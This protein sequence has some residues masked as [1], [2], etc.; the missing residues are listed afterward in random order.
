MD[1]NSTHKTLYS[2][3]D[4]YFMVA[5]IYSEQNAQRSPT[6]TFAHFVE[7]C[8]ML[9]LHDNNKKREGFEV[10]DALCKALGWFF[11]LLAKFRVASVETLIFRKFPYAC[12]YC[13]KCPHVDKECKTTQGAKRTVDHMAVKLKLEEN[14]SKRPASLNQWRQM[15][16]DIYPRD[17]NSLGK[18][19]ST[20]GLLEELGELAEAVRVFDRHPKYFAGEVADVFSYLMGIANELRL[21]QQVAAKPEFDFNAEFLRRYPGLCVQC[22]HE[23]CVCPSVPESTVGRLAKEL[24]LTDSDQVFAAEFVTADQRGKRVGSSVLQEL[25][26]LA[27]IAHQLPLDRGD[28]NRAM[29]LLCL[30]IAEEIRPRSEQLALQ[31]HNAAF[32]IAADKRMAG[33]RDR[34]DTSA[35][36][37]SLLSSVWPLL[38]LAVIPEGTTLQARLAKLLRAQA[39]TIGI[40]TALPEEFAAMRLMLDEESSNPV[41]GDPNDYFVGTIGAENGEGAHTVLVTMLKDMGNNSATAAATHLLRSFPHVEDVL[42]VGIAG[43]IPDP[44]SPETHVRLGDVVVSNKEGVVQ[45]DNLKLGMTNL[46]IRS[47]ADRPSARLLGAVKLLETDE[48]LKKFPWEQFISRGGDMAQRPEDNQ[49]QLF[50]WSKSVPSLIP[51]PSD[52]GRRAGL[53]KIHYGRIGASNV[54]LKNPQLRDQ[55]RKNCGVLAVEMEGSGVAD[56]T[57]H[58]GQSYMVIRGISDYC[59]E[60]KNDVWHAYAAVVAAAYARAVI[61]KVKL[62]TNLRSDACDAEHAGAAWQ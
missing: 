62:V 58:T 61:S 51:H 45:Y 20:V 59:D 13:R 6:R 31:L 41:A 50:D 37:V 38:K 40:V 46:K 39:A 42:M 30:R 4:L 15:F 32:L 26:G 57:W 43:G 48:Y 12:P 28:T 24:D 56:A 17:I 44:T 53:P 35:A 10:E 22:G 60:K 47:S 3:D 21:S 49:D 23:V 33:S 52:P 19:R 8:G 34:G 2:L 27:A 7:V 16:E 54:L 25:G 18:A 14:S 29:T 9:A 55:L 11:P 5:S 36:A 1:Q